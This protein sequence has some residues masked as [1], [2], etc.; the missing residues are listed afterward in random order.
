MSVPPLSKSL[1]WTRGIIE[2][3][4]KLFDLQRQLATGKK[5]ATYGTLGPDRTLS[6]AM[7]SRTSI[8]DAY[9]STIQTISLRMNVMTQAI[10]RFSN[11]G[12]EIR[13]D[14]MVP[15]Y[16]LTDGNRSSTQ[17][18]A[19]AALDEALSLLRSEVGGRYLFAGRRTDAEPVEPT[20]AI[21]DGAGAR[22]GFKQH[23]SERMQADM[24]ADGL[25]RLVVPV[26]AA[27]DVAIS[28]DVDGSPF[29]FKI[30]QLAT[31]LTGT[32]AT[33]PAGVPPQATLSFSAT[34]PEAGETVR[35]TLSMPDG[36]ETVVELTAVAAGE[37]GDPGTF[38]IGADETTTA[39]NFQAALVTSLETEAATELRAASGY[40]AADDFFNMDDANPPQ[41]VDGPPFDT[42]TALRDGTPADTVFW[43]LGDGDLTTD[44]RS[45]AIARIDESISVAYGAR[46]NEEA[47]RWTIQNLAV[48]AAQ[49]FDPNNPDV[50][51]ERYSA[52][53]SRVVSNLSFPDKRQTVEAI[54]AE[55]TTAQYVS[56]Q[57][58]ERHTATKATAVQLLSEVEVA[59]RDEVA[60]KILQLQTRLEASYQTTA[61]LSQLS[62]VNFL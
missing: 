36:T 17:L 26:P 53:T 23:L 38:E 61:V 59:D 16:V 22:A 45:T 28:E 40:A 18:R 3:R 54:Y 60:V 15:D 13:T 48:L 14:A 12:R 47:F 4:E 50:E 21:M 10:D 6:I 43:Y 19:E 57:A 32:T 5:A 2:S 52:M 34:L 8:T 39:A 46:G 37:G 62:L 35:L 30:V 33:G 55:I 25:G 9:K 42:A 27:A 51:R 11:I 7:R 49:T 29:G 56:G 31:T 44:S 1:G 58:D 24:G 41:R 20:P